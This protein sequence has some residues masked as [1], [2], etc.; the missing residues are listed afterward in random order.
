MFTKLLVLDLD[1]T[2]VHTVDGRD[3]AEISREPDFEIPGG[4]AVYKRPG[5]C[6]FLASCL[7]AFQ[8]VGVWTAG[9][10]R[11]AH[12]VLPHLCNVQDFAFVWGRERCTSWFDLET[13]E[14]VWI[15]D[16]RKLQRRGYSKKSI[17]FIDDTA[18]NLMRS[19][20]N[21]VPVRSWHGDLEDEEL[22]QL[23]RYLETLGELPNVRL[24][25]K[26]GWRRGKDR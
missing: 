21:L 16:I 1:E 10:R 20:G 26:R 2:L 22:P 6:K 17:L 4:H 7:G 12:E 13:R 18:Q 5:V 23:F 15:K 9:T 19:Y 3:L 14:Q 11:Y 24:I 8:E 25:D